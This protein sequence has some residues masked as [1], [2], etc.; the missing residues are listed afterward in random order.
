[1]LIEHWLG[2]ENREHLNNLGLEVI[3]EYLWETG[4]SGGSCILVEKNLVNKVK[5]SSEYERFAV[6]NTTQNCVA[7]INL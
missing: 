3:T 4:K 5:I 2:W 7:E 6:R 1:M